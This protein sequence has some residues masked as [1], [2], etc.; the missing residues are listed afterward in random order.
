MSKHRS[1]KQKVLARGRTLF[2]KK[3]NNIKTAK[4]NAEKNKNSTAQKD[5]NSTDDKTYFWTLK[6][7]EGTRAITFAVK[8]SKIF[9]GKPFKNIQ[10]THSGD[11]YKNIEVTLTKDPVYEKPEFRHF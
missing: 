10:H 9:V 1:K 3:L 8:G 5:K 11:P 6:M 4:E 7:P 2:A